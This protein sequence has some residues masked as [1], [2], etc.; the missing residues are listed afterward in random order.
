[1][2]LAAQGEVSHLGGPGPTG[3]GHLNML[4]AIPKRACKCHS[5]NMAW[6]AGWNQL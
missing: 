2:E 4:S 5:L 1:M 3:E 6:R